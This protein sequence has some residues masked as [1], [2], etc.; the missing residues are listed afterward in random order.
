M[1][2]DYTRILAMNVWRPYVFGV[3][4]NRSAR[5]VTLAVPLVIDTGS[6]RCL[7][8]VDLAHEIGIN[9]IEGGAL[10]GTAGLGGRVTTA[11]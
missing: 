4:L 10:S 7:F 5:R 2:F 1:T 11:V 8:N 9:P 6:D 3:L